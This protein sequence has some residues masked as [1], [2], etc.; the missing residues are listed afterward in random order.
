MAQRRLSKDKAVAL[1]SVLKVV[2][3]DTVKH[4]EDREDN[5]TTSK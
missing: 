3:K 4:I 5:A 2:K 1:N